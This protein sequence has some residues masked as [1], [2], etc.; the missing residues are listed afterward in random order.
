[1]FPSPAFNNT[2]ASDAVGRSIIQ[3]AEN[4]SH[5]RFY[6]SGTAISDGCLQRDDMIQPG[7]GGLTLCLQALMS[8]MVKTSQN[9]KDG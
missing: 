9:S 2:M 5:S 1:M 7:K 3:L 6:S 8:M 4:Q